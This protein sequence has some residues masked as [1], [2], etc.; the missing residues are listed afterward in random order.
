MYFPFLLL[1]LSSGIKIMLDSC[2][3]SGPMRMLSPPTETLFLLII[4]QYTPSLNKITQ[5]SA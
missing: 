2:N 3:V 4:A 5:I 1:S